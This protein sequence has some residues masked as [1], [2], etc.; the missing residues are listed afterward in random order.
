MRFIDITTA[1]CLAV[2]LALTGC[3]EETDAPP[4]A[5]GDTTDADAATQPAADDEAPRAYGNSRSTLGKAQDSAKSTIG[6][7]EA[8]DRELQKQ[9]DDDRP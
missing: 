5:Y 3:Y 6:D 1:A 2:T 4:P 9:I 8:R 7:L